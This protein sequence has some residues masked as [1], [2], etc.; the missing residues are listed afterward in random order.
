[1]TTTPV[2]H[3][4][5]RAVLGTSV[6]TV[7]WL[8]GALGSAFI[9]EAVRGAVLAVASLFGIGALIALVDTVEGH[10]PPTMTAA[11]LAAIESLSTRF[12][13]YGCC[14][15]AACVS[16]ATYVLDAIALDD[17]PADVRALWRKPSCPVIPVENQ[18]PY[19][20][21]GSDGRSCADYASPS[22]PCSRGTST[23]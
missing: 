18:Q 1:M 5:H 19:I 4:K 22:S 12:A 3:W 20:N 6:L 17:L 13:R 2:Q 15:A 9:D 14:M 11:Y 7:H 23:R 21:A 10:Q 8:C 16:A